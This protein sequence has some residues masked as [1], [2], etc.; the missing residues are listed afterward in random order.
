M[1]ARYIGRADV[2]SVEGISAAPSRVAL[3]APRDYFS[4]AGVI[5]AGPSPTISMTA[6]SSLAPS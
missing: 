6:G 4:S 1:A 2:S 5:V 3:R